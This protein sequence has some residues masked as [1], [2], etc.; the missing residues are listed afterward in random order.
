MKTRSDTWFTDEPVYCSSPPEEDTT[1]APVYT[2]S[3][4]VQ[5]STQAA[6]D[7]ADAQYAETARLEN[8]RIE[9]EKEA[10]RIQALINQVV[11]QESAVTETPVP[12]ERTLI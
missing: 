5:H 7:A 11:A 6:A 8:E 2:D 9:A 3:A 1:P 10:E 12:V 4:G